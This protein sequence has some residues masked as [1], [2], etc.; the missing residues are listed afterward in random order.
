[1]ERFNRR[2]IILAVWL[3]SWSALPATAQNLPPPRPAPMPA[4]PAPAADAM[5][6]ESAE[7]P[8]QKSPLELPPPPS[9]EVVKLKLPPL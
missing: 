9:G 6:G 5:Q 4:D 2:T 1:M 3:L 8:S 7:H